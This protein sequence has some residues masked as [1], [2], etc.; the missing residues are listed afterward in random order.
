MSQSWVQLADALPRK[1]AEVLTGD[2]AVDPGTEV[3]AA[4]HKSAA[5]GAGSYASVL[6]TSHLVT[7]GGLQ[8]LEAVCAYAVQE[9]SVMYALAPIDEEGQ[10]K[11]VRDCAH[12]G[13]G[14]IQGKPLRIHLFVEQEGGASYSHFA[15]PLDNALEGREVC[16]VCVQTLAG[17]LHC[18]YQRTK[19][20]EHV[21]AHAPFAVSASL[22]AGP[23]TVVDPTDDEL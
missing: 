13:T 19:V 23:A 3:V 1:V 17:A 12:H 22:P 18:V 2:R 8:R 7:P 6:N 9:T 11:V 10:R 4:T 15:S 21:V 20:A 16:L 5:F 14:A